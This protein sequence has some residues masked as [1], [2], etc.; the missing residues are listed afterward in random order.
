MPDI[1]V[2]DAAEVA[3]GSSEGRSAWSRDYARVATAIAWLDA[4][5]V[6]QPRV[7]E[8]AKALNLSPSHLHRTFVRFAGVS[9]HRLLRWLTLGAAKQLLR[10][11]ATVLETATATGLS[12]TGRLHDLTVT[13][14]AVTPGE[15][16]RGGAGLTI[17]HARHPTPLGDALVATTDRGVLALRFL[18][19]TGP[20]EDDGVAALAD[21]WPAATLV[22]D[23]VA[24][25]P[26][27]DH[28]AAALG[29]PGAASLG[30]GGPL[31]V[32]AVGTNLQVKVWEALLRIPDD[33]VVTYAEVAR[34][35]GRPGAV[36]PVAGAV[37]RNPVAALIP[38][39]R[40]LRTSGGLGGYRWGTT[41]KRALLARE[42]ARADDVA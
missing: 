36:R 40:V 33:R 27:A 42:A 38:C 6:S 23:P 29:A 41:R 39:H 34:A 28:L 22:A 25:R 1:E 9:P 24:T 30:R 31:P 37:G 14:E 10:E 17:H 35:A 18:D 13:L 3:G 26:V 7:E 5:Q 2:G 11:R 8:L 32:L 15:I 19:P 12:S 4:H 20:G 16:G 21:E